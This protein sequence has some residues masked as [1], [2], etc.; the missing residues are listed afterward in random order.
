MF[1]RKLEGITVAGRDK[2]RATAFLFLSYCG[3]QKILGFVAGRL[4]IGEPTSVDKLGQHLEL[5]YELVI[6]FAA[7]LVARERLMPVSG[8]IEAIPADED[9]AWLL[10]LIEL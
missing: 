8:F 6:K 9:R 7:S 2:N 3:S 4:G 1:S 5:L 10:R